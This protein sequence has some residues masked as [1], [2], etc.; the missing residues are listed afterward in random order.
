MKR[1]VLILVIIIGLLG[2]IKWLFL[3][4][5][6]ADGQKA[7][8]KPGMNPTLVNVTSYIARESKVENKILVAGTILANE[9]AQLVPETSG[10]IISMNLQEGKPVAKG[11]LLVKINDVDLQAQL[12]KLQLQEK[13]AVDNESREKK[14]LNVNGISQMEYDG[15]LTQ[16]NSVRADIEITQAQIAKTEIR[17]PFSGIVGLKNISEGNYVSSSTTIADIEQI[18]PIKIDF[19]VAEKY[20]SLVQPGSIIFFTTEETRKDTFEAKVIATDPKIDIATRTVKAR[21]LCPNKQGKILPG[22]FASIQIILKESENSFMIPSQA[23]IPILTGFKVYVVKNG[24]AHESNVVAGLRTESDVQ[25]LNG[26]KS[27]DTIVTTGIQQLKNGTLVK[28]T[29]VQ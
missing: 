27:G 20:A 19:S 15:V 22:S 18:D 23:L 12:K 7:S 3:S 25:V 14:L 10:K 16:L 8:G 1:F 13:L 6:S 26:I 9:E 21:A 5:P 4:N 17:A 28:I 29:F 2:A 11:E 24:K